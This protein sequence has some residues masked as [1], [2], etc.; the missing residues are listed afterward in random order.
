MG[1]LDFLK[2][3]NLANSKYYDANVMIT[4][5]QDI[6]G[7]DIQT[8][9]KELEELKIN[10]T[11]EQIKEFLDNKFKEEEPEVKARIEKRKHNKST[12][13]KFGKLT[14][15]EIEESSKQFVDELTAQRY[16]FDSYTLKYFKNYSTIVRNKAKQILEIIDKIIDKKYADIVDMLID[17]DINLSNNSIKNEDVIRLVE[18]FIYNY[19][20][21][22]ETINT[23]NNLETYLNL[24]LSE[25]LVYKYGN[26]EDDLYPT[27][28]IHIKNLNN[29]YLA[30]N[31]P[32]SDNE[33]I[34]L[35]E[36]R[37]RNMQRII[38]E[39]IDD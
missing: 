39:S 14:D 34:A 32:L 21:F 15:E 28:A 35:E 19:N 31:I 24:K 29:D 20:L 4:I 37:I 10:V 5:L 17:L 12:T 18:P 22:I 8:I 7:K 16:D 6:L 1:K 9:K 11:E 33:R 27:T 25:H 2:H 30:G 13:I 23:A 36:K 3:F 38:R 26:S